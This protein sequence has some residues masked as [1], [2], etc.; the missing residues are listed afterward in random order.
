MIGVGEYKWRKELQSLIQD[1]D[2]V[3]IPK[4]YAPDEI[5]ETNDE[6]K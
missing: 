2:D 1:P 3:P 4:C 6:N 5:V